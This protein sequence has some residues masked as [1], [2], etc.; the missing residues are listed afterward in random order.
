MLGL[1]QQLLESL[2]P[3][4]KLLELINPRYDSVLRHTYEQS[5][6]TLQMSMGTSFTAGRFAP[7]AAV[8]CCACLPYEQS[9][10]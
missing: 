9:C 2:Q 3:L 1:L 8:S 4:R 6:R 5:R 7:A 10:L